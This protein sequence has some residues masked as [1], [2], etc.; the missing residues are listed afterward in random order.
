MAGHAFALLDR[1][2]ENHEAPCLALTLARCT[3]ADT[4]TTSATAAG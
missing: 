2:A 3:L 1:E 4:A